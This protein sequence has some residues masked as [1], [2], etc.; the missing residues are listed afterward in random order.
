MKFDDV[1]V[2]DMRKVPFHC[3]F[4]LFITPASVNFMFCDFIRKIY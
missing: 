4:I 3:S 1:N 2:I